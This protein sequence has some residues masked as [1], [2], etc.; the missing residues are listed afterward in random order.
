MGTRSLN[1]PFVLRVTAAPVTW[2]GDP[3]QAMSL[4]EAEDGSRPKS[5]QSRKLALDG[6][7]SPITSFLSP[8]SCLMLL[9]QVPKTERDPRDPWFWLRGNDSQVVYCRWL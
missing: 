3:A 5:L 2:R 8:K 7:H 6:F 1:W 4:P 9:L